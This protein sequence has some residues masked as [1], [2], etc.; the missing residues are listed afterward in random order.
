MGGSCRSE[1]SHHRL[2]CAG[3]AASP[4]HLAQDDVAVTVTVAA[5]FLAAHA[6]GQTNQGNAIFT[7]ETTSRARQAALATRDNGGAPPAAGPR[8]PHLA[9]AAWRSGRRQKC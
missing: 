3:C 9:E 1:E 5:S 8:W 7:V 2:P 6:A 4:G